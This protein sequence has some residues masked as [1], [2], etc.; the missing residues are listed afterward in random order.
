MN[1]EGIPSSVNQKHQQEF[2]QK[3]IMKIIFSMRKT[4]N[5]SRIIR[6]ELSLK[7]QD[8]LP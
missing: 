7:A 6:K 8:K 5:N 4:R 2:S 3:F 1:S